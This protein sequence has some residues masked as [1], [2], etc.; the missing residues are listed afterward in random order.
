MSDVRRVSA[1]TLRAM[2]LD[3]E[4]LA[5]LD[6][7]EERI[8]SESHLL[9]ARCV[10]LSRLELKLA[11]FVPRR[12]TRIVLVDDA[13]GLAERAASVLAKAG[14]T[15]VSMLDGGNAAWEAAGFTLSTEPRMADEPLDYWPKPYE[16]ADDAKGAMNE[17]LSWEVDLLPR[18]ERDGTTRFTTPI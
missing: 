11:R 18:I 12:T 13:E 5:L 15:D 6:L 1:E 3:G 9:F 2:L 4:E 8:F 16:R 10:P 14:Y 17:Y 7:R